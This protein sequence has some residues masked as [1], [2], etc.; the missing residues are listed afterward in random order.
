VCREV[1]EFDGPSYSLWLERSDG[2]RVGEAVR[3]G[4]A[5]PCNEIV[6][7]PDGRLLA[8]LVQHVA[9]V[10]FVDV[11]AGEMG[12][13][14]TGWRQ[15]ALSPEARLH[16]GR[17]LRFVE[18]RTVE[19]VVCP[20]EPRAGCLSPESAVRVPVPDWKSAG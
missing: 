20:S 3:F 7:S 6:W 12:R 14:L 19:L 11:D 10:Q 1:P 15:I 16:R 9:T 8:V 5:D 18:P 17:G 4:D 2:H 13:G